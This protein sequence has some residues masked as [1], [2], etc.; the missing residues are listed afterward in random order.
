MLVLA[1]LLPSL[2]FGAGV[3]W[4]LVENYRRAFEER[5]TDTARALGLAVDNEIETHF[6]VLTALAASPTLDGCGGGATEDG[7]CDLGAFDAH[8]RRAAE[9]LGTEV[10]LIGPDL[11][12]AVNTS[13]PRGVP[14]PVT[15]AAEA[16]RR[17]LE[18]GKPEVIDLVVGAV[19]RRP[20]AAV[21][22]PVLREGR[23]VGVLATRLD[24]DR[25][26][27][28]LAAQ[29][30]RNGEAGGGI[31]AMLLD[32]RTTVA[33]RS[34]GHDDLAG[35]PAPDWYAQAVAGRGR[36][37]AHGPTLDAGDAL[38]AFQ[39]L[40]RAPGWTLVVAE[41]LAAYRASWRGPLLGLAAG[42]AAAL[43]LGLALAVALARRTLR[44]VAALVRHAKAVAAGAGRGPEAPPAVA[45]ADVAEFEALRVA[46]E[47]AEA[48]LREGEDRLRRAQEAGGVGAW[49]WDI[50][51]GRV[52]WSDGYYQIWGIDPAEPASYEGF[53]RHVLPE[54]RP[55]LEAALAEVLR[56]GGRWRHE[57]RI[58]RPSDGALRWLAGEGEVERDAATGRPIRMAGVN[59]DV[60]ERRQ[61]EEHRALLMRELVHR[62]KNMLNVVQAAVRLTPRDDPEAYARAVEGRVA[63]L[64]RAH[65]LLAE[66]RWSGAELRPL[67]EAELAPFLHGPPPATGAPPVAELEGPPV[68]LAP[69]AAQALSMALHELATNATK[70]GALSAPGGRVSVSWGVDAAAGLLRLR[71]VE[72][73][74]PVPAGPPARRGFGS[75]VVEA[76]VRDQLGGAVERRWEAPGLVCEL[77]APLERVLA[78]GA[79]RAA[80]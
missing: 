18:S 10:I 9:A 27:G 41:P 35:R 75:R 13:L 67:A 70:H 53:L 44:P 15:G 79:A 34:R 63:A 58:R 68:V 7:A 62:T 29:T 31:F 43:A 57:F 38:V 51:S 8:A 30:S 1:V 74:G 60:T 71:W 47:D 6:A 65:I 77:T 26:R 14:L 4:H 21:L 32:G 36:G 2:A 50:A 72:R 40:S 28:I 42:G 23:R 20:V 37:L 45:P 55:A 80:A 66:T 46:I 49:E 33:A 11:R 12:Q 3:A 61:G 17:V 73:G 52:H 16:A 19:A 64:A 22:A 54:D 24:P 25:L 39:R 59:R 5:L 78:G 69:E 48:A 56:T 76:T